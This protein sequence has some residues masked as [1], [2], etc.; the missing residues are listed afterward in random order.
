MSRFP[1]N[2]SYLRTMWL[3]HMAYVAGILVNVNMASAHEPQLLADH[4]VAS[5]SG[6]RFAI[7]ERIDGPILRQSV[8]TVCIKIGSLSNHANPAISES[9][10]VESEIEMN[11]TVF[12]ITG[13]PW[14]DRTRSA[15]ILGVLK[16]ESPPV[17]VIVSDSDWGILLLDQFGMNR[18][19]VLGKRPAL[20][21]LSPTG[22]ALWSLSIREL[23]GND[24]V[25]VADGDN[26][27]DPFVPWIVD[28]WLDDDPGILH[29]I[30]DVSQLKRDAR[31]ID[32]VRILHRI[33]RMDDGS[34]SDVNDVLLLRC[35]LSDDDRVSFAAI[36]ACMNRSVSS[37]IIDALDQVSR[38]DDVSTVARITSLAV[39]TSRRKMNDGKRTLRE[40]VRSNRPPIRVVDSNICE[41]PRPFQDRV[42]KWLISHSDS[43]LEGEEAIAL[44][45]VEVS[46][47]Y[48]GAEIRDV[49]E[50]NRGHAVRYLSRQSDEESESMRKARVMLLKIAADR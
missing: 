10:R 39:V 19:V 28:V 7:V 31:V 5:N 12:R 46:A 50:R 1:K 30:A 26:S 27:L 21:R 13:R 48:F 37:L 33:V 17:K 3:A 9:A 18:N 4:I 32:R 25:T 44:L 24:S 49:V 2:G 47:G 36:G 45:M 29:L 23:L 16:L 15:H 34:V 11:S 40:W 22:S 43:W 14:E 35:A 42:Y 41:L 38:S 6:R 20:Q 8:G